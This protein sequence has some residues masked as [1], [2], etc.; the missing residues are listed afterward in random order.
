[1]TFTSLV[2]TS[3]HPQMVCAAVMIFEYMKSRASGILVNVKSDNR[4]KNNWNETRM[5]VT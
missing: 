4:A 1:M 2:V 3:F 5:R